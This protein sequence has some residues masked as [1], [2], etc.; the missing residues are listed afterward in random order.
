VLRSQVC[1]LKP[2]TS[3][4]ATNER[5]L[6]AI[7]RLAHDGGAAADLLLEVLQHVQRLHQHQQQQQQQQQE[8]PQ[9][10][11]GGPPAS[12]AAGKEVGMFVPPH[13]LTEEGFLAYVAQRNAVLAG[14]EARVLTAL[15]K[16]LMERS[17]PGGPGRTQVLA[18]ARALLV[19]HAQ[20]QWHMAPEGTSE[21]AAGGPLPLPPEGLEP[22]AEGANGGGSRAQR[23]GPGS[24][25]G[26]VWRG[27]L[28]SYSPQKGEEFVCHLEAAHVPPAWHT[29]W[30]GWPRW[31]RCKKKSMSM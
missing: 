3:C 2:F 11:Q 5:L 13:L 21:E 9:A 7:G 25:R 8:Q 15:A 14:H 10:E 19:E 1:I 28:W 20:C 26:G 22:W 27:E 30:V 6:V 31:V 4:A 18:R 16:A 24:R 23:P 29:R 12:S 17:P